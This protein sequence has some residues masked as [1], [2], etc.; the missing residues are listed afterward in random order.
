MLADAIADIHARSRGTYGILRVK[1]AL[2]LE[3]GL[4]VNTK[5]VRRIMNELGIQGLPGPK[6]GY[7]NLKNART[8]EDLVQRQFTATR[9]NELWLTDIT[10]HPTS[11]G[12]LY[13]CVVL[14]LY[15]R[16][17]WLGHPP[18]ESVLVLDATNKA[19]ESRRT[20]P[21]TVIHS[22]H[23]TQFTSW[24]F[25]EN[26]RRLGLLSSMGT[27]GDCYDNAPM[28]SFWGSMQIELLNR[29]SWRTK[30]ELALAMADYID[31]STIQTADTVR[32]AISLR[33]NS[34]PYSTTTQP[35][36]LS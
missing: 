35:A 5:L 24:A 20:S 31:T 13:C 7:K 12:K 18:C 19:G 22:D 3:Q 10:E 17:R 26:V 25:T 28:E 6:K 30:M 21:T 15:S 2:E 14:D 4:I 32:S 1:A 9:P 34:K 36:T 29:Q 27:V 23:G 33:T 8:C 11:E 16:K